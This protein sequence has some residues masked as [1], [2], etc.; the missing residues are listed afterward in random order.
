MPTYGDP[1]YAVPQTGP[2]TDPNADDGV[3]T[4]DPRSK[5]DVQDASGGNEPGDPG[6]LKPVSFEYTPQAQAMGEEPGRK[7][8]VMATD[9]LKTAMGKDMVYRDPQSGF[10]KVNYIRGLP[11]MLAGIADLNQRLARLE[12]GGKKANGQP[13]S[14]GLTTADA[15]Q[16]SVLR[17]KGDKD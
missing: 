17:L 3:A 13:S 16:S 5:T 2:A 11:D 8:G 4:S 14:A 6:P 10:L 7:M 15:A 9:L 12:G 1:D